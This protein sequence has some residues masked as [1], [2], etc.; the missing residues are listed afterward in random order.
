MEAL[1]IVDIFGRRRVVAICY[2]QPAE[3]T[4][5]MKKYLLL[6]L[7]FSLTTNVFGQIKTIKVRRIDSTSCDY[8]F[9]AD[10]N[11]AD[12]FLRLNVFTFSSPDKLQRKTADEV[13]GKIRFLKEKTFYVNKL[14]FDSLIKDVCIVNKFK[15][16]KVEIKESGDTNHIHIDLTYKKIKKQ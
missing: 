13:R 3:Q 9:I 12:K 5:T 11:V 4:S 7:I 10:K 14:Y 1:K 16:T 15:L 6:I 2:K 8:K